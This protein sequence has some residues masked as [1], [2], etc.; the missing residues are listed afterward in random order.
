MKIMYIKKF[1][2]FKKYF[3][4]SPD[5]TLLMYKKYILLVLNIFKNK[6]LYAYVVSLVNNFINI[7]FNY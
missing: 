3:Q 5:S 2:I 4:Q 1:K 7:K 6:Q